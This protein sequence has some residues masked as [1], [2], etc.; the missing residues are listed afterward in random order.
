MEEKKINQHKLSR[1]SETLESLCSALTTQHQC[2]MVLA[3]KIKRNDE[4]VRKREVI[5]AY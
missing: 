5:N 4:R 2:N 1:T 3:L